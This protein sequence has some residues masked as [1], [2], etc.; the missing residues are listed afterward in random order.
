VTTR[1]SR[2]CSLGA[3][4]FALALLTPAAVLGC[5]ALPATP[6]QTA[7]STSPTAGTAG[8]VPGS[9]ERNEFRPAADALTRVVLNVELEQK[10]TN[11]RG[12]QLIPTANGSGIIVRQ[13][14]YI[15]TNDHVV[16]GADNVDVDLGA[17][18]L[19]ARIIGRDP[20][21]DLAVI[22]I[23]RTGL[24]VAPIGDPAAL[25]VGEWVLAVGSPFGLD[26]SVSAGIVSAMHRSTLSPDVTG[27][28]AS[29]YTDLIQTD[30]SINPGNSGGAL[31][32]L[33]G[34]VVGV[35]TIVESPSG[36]SA[37]VGFAIPIDFAMSV[38]DQLI[39]T[40]HAEH[41]YLGTN[42]IGIDAHIAFELGLNAAP[43]A[44]GALVQAVATSSPAE[45]AGF[46]QADVITSIGGKPVTDGATYWAALRAQKIGATVPVTIVRGGKT[47]T[48][49]VTIGSSTRG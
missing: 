31:G 5:S 2:L 19:R 7:Q 45:K 14:G 10:F 32:T 23:D 12:T 46:Q 47:L 8:A 40:G 28:A 48:L 9:D 22:K 39:R 42:V 25:G 35:N 11:S 44:Q 18:H 26:H 3:A 4:L 38:A 16:A 34:K 29:A 15:L 27:T 13:D 20:S 33:D 6:T 49:Q 17:R 1:T 43:T 37:G 36:S 41:P 30:A 24:P 21:T